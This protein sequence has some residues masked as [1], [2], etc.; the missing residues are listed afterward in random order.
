MAFRILTTEEPLLKRGHYV[1]F[2]GNW[3][4]KYEKRFYR[5]THLI[6]FE[7]DYRAGYLIATATTPLT[8][9]PDA[10]I[11]FEPVYYDTI[12]QVRHGFPTGINVYLRWPTGDYR[13]KLEDAAFQINPVATDSTKFIGVLSAAKPAFGQ[14][15]GEMT[16]LTDATLTAGPAIPYNAVL[17][18]NRIEISN[19]VTTDVRIVCTDT[20]TDTDGNA[21]SVM[22]FDYPLVPG[23]SIGV[24]VEKS[25]K[26]LGQLN[27]QAVAGTP[28]VA[29]PVRVFAGGEL[30][31]PKLNRFF[32]FVYVR[33]WMPNYFVVCNGLVDYEK[34]I[35]SCLVNKLKIKAVEDEGTRRALQKGDIPVF[36]LYHYSEYEA[37]AL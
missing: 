28:T 33:D 31:E 25:K 32:E 35:F 30:E 12:Y 3:G 14:A 22:L 16:S 9:D 2:I 4:D 24:D 6:Q 17:W 8:V 29:N 18:L 13:G 27:F 11:G 26:A 1:E 15:A 19:H 37:T 10:N 5:V 20:F 36:P 7:R 34:V 21:A 23:Q